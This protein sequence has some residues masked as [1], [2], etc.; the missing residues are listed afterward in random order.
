MSSHNHFYYFEF[1]VLG[2]GV[3]ISDSIYHLG[4]SE[5]QDKKTNMDS[6][7]IGYDRVCV[8]RPLVFPCDWR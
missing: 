7:A 8:C 5:P 1:S 3:I 6:H 4:G 2:N